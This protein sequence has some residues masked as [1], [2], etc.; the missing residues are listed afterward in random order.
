[1]RCSQTRPSCMRCLKQDTP[2]VY[3]ISQRA[4]RHRASSRSWQP[5]PVKQEWILNDVSPQQEQKP[6]AANFQYSYPISHSASPSVQETIEIPNYAPPTTMY[7]AP[8]MLDI[9][10]LT[11]LESASEQF[12]AVDDFF[13]YPAMS[14]YGSS[15][16]WYQQDMNRGTPSTSPITRCSSLSDNQSP[17]SRGDSAIMCGCTSTIISF[18]STHP[19]PNQ[20]PGAVDAG[21]YHGYEAIKL[22]SQVQACPL[23]R[24][25]NYMTGNAVALLISHIIGIYEKAIRDQADSVEIYRGGGEMELAGQGQWNISPSMGA[26]GAPGGPFPGYGASSYYQRSPGPV[27]HED[28]RQL[29]AEKMANQ[30]EMVE[31]LI[32]VFAAEQQPNGGQGAYSRVQQSPEITHHERAAFNGLGAMLTDKLIKVRSQWDVIGARPNK[33]HR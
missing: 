4:G 14:S 13:E 25:K 27:H 33:G 7:S 22:C 31:T 9:A 23:C 32:A 24:G 16:R 28:S 2:C 11:N 18:L 3:G 19:F 12:P 20:G 5:Q 1:M 15:G 17:S 10:N 6:A 26:G 30:L 29:K 21:L 8:Q